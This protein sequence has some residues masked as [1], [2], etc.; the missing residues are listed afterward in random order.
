VCHATDHSAQVLAIDY[1]SEGFNRFSN[2][3]SIDPAHRLLGYNLAIQCG[4][5]QREGNGKTCDA[6]HIVSVSSAW[7]QNDY[8]VLLLH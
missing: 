1:R 6:L 7:S 2:E 4:E 3:L 8:D 5:G